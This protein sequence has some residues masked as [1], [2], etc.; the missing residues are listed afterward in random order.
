M[1]DRTSSRDELIQ[2]A[3]DELR[4]MV[5]ENAKYFNGL[6]RLEEDYHK[7]CKTLTCCWEEL[8]DCN[9]SVAVHFQNALKEHDKNISVKAFP[10]S[11]VP[12]QSVFPRH[13]STQSAN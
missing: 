11:L 12:L 10:K 4:G 1:A 7:H 8:I 5:V 9:D 13:R 2:Q 3:L 6:L